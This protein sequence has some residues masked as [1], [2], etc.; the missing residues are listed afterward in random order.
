MSNLLNSL[1]MRRQTRSEKR[2]REGVEG[3]D[4]TSKRTDTR[5]AYDATSSDD[6]GPEEVFD[7]CG[8]P[9]SG[10]DIVF[11]HGLRGSRVQTWSKG[12]IFWPRDLLKDD[13]ENA[14]AI[15]WGYDAKVANG[16]SWA[17]KESLFGHANTLLTD[18]SRLRRGIKRP[19]IF[20]CHSLGG[21]VVKEA[22]ITSDSYKNH[23][24]HPR[25]AAIYPRTIGV[26]FMGTPH[27]GSH[28]ATYGEVAA[29]VARLC[30]QQPN[31]QLLQ[32]LREDSHILEK[33]REDFTTV[34]QDMYIVCV[35]E[36]LPTAAGLI[37][38]EASASYDGFNVTRGSIHAN[39]MDMVKFLSGDEGYKR[40]LGYI[41]DILDAKVPH[42]ADRDD[43]MTQSRIDDI[44]KALWFPAIDS[45]EEG[46]DEA[47][48]KTCSWIIDGEPI[49]DDGTPATPSR[50]SAWLQ[51]NETFFWI[52]GKAGCGKSTL[53]KYVYRNKRTKATLENS[54]WTRGKD[55]ILVAYF[56]FERGSND[57]KSREGMLRSILYQ[58]LSTRREL[59]PKVFSQ[60]H[61]FDDR[62][63]LEGE[64]LLVRGGLVEFA[65]LKKAFASMLDHLQD[66][67]LFLFLDGLDE[68]RMVKRTNEYTEEQLDLIY[69]GDN[70]DEA[71][72]RS[73]WITDGHKEIANFLHSLKTRKNV[74][75]CL[76]SRELNIFEHEFR[77]FPR[78][79]VHEHS[80][81][82]I[83]RYC[84]G[85]LTEEAPELV[86]LPKFAQAITRRSCGVF[87]W[88]RLVI[89]MLVDGYMNGDSKKELLIT[90]ERLPQ[91]LGGKD[92]LYS[93][94]IRN[95]RRE[96]LLES[97]RLFLLVV[98][99]HGLEH[100]DRSQPDIITLFLAEQGHLEP[101]SRD[102]LRA[103]SGGYESKTWD[104][105][106]PKCNELS[107]RLKSRCGGLLEGTKPVQFMHQTAKQFLT[108]RYIW[109]RMFPDD[110][111][112][113]VAFDVELGLM[114][115]FIRRLKGCSEAII[116][117][118][119]I[120]I[121]PQATAPVQLG[122]TEDK[123]MDPFKE[124]V[125]PAF[126]AEL[127]D[128]TL[129]CARFKYHE[130]R[131]ITAD[132]HRY[133]IKLLDEL[134]NVGS[135]LTSPVRDLLKTPDFS[136]VSVLVGPRHR[137]GK[138]RN[139]GPWSFLRLALAYDLFEYLKTK[140]RHRGFPTS[141]LAPLLVF[142]SEVNSFSFRGRESGIWGSYQLTVVEML[143]REGVDPNSL[144]T[145]DCGTVTPEGGW[146]I[147]TSFLQQ[148]VETY[149]SLL[150]EHYADSWI[151]T[152]KLFLRYGADTAVRWY[153]K[154]DPLGEDKETLRLF[155][156][157]RVIKVYLGRE[158]QYEKELDELLE[159]L[160]HTEEESFSE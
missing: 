78:I 3:G 142:A 117:P 97:R 89:D 126:A 158:P 72:G 159:L 14:R 127:F 35:R 94:M 38:P 77:T 41:E 136:W 18:L 63:P 80:A 36:E 83:V 62:F 79:K 5:Q 65:N 134:D 50:F 88:V 2:K 51:N 157:E 24:R 10:V 84:E 44:L 30:F 28:Q 55:L 61:I 49:H 100:K 73:I 43:D 37:V 92:G 56:I 23:K 22:L 116:T 138:D 60:W 90:L 59:V 119:K 120:P 98:R 27:R 111:R 31:S 25:L 153:G 146:T 48:A 42:E 67:N 82:S 139:F 9:T 71:W 147:W 64:Y 15:T 91:R 19:I 132:Q 1:S 54:Q 112:F 45:R 85:R 33:Q 103:K 16:F 137:V 66:S 145:E 133:C 118:D 87:L 39:H 144:N 128:L 113:P 96:Y 11:V 93:L 52:S 101:G 107:R 123:F 141:Q 99:C 130:T 34:S 21:L 95:I 68:Y 74:K 156:P 86:D 151:K 4:T 131:A 58:V 109:D 152:T 57:Q 154:G 160:H 104:D 13:V 110:V 148:T 155:T 75:V 17:S 102:K 121:K 106:Q 122:T 105:L 12:D 53:M 76:S 81:Q 47:Y 8:G 150:F 69:D 29:N 143:L 6:V 115:G 70:E 129:R 108:R 125:A 40:T 114:S 135:Q 20:V 124:F 149:V 46:I 32:T 140:I 7:S 26:V